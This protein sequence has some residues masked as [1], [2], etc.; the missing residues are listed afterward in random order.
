MIDFDFGIRTKLYFGP[1]KEK[2]VGSILNSYGAKRVL[3]VIGQGSVK[4][5]GLL[6][7]VISSLEAAKLQYKVIEGVRPN[8]T[9][10]FVVEGLKNIFLNM[11][12]I[13][14]L[15]VVDQLSIPQN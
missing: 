13:Y 11:L 14:E 7:V 4:K 6:D 8:P 5:S 9:I 12:N 15:L 1:D 2:Q 3:V 10:D